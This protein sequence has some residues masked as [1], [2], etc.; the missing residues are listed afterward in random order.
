LFHLFRIV[1]IA[2]ADADAADAKLASNPDWD[3]LRM[4]I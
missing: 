2:P 1:E 3:R 4:R